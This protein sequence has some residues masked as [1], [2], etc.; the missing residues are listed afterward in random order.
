MERKGIDVSYHQGIIDWKKVKNDG[1]TFAIIRAGYGKKTQDKKF[2]NNIIGAINEGLDI[3]IYWFIYADNVADSVANAEF[4]DI[5]IKLYKSKINLKIWADWEYDSDKRNPQSKASRTDIVEAFC[6][7]LK[8]KGYDVGVYAN[9]DYITSK[10]DMSQ[11]S[12]YPLWLARYSSSKGSYNPFMWQYSSKG[13]VSGIKGN[14][15]MNIM[16][17][18][19]STK[20]VYPTLKVGSKGEYVKIVQKKVGCKVDGDFGILTKN[21]VIVFQEQNGLVKDGI[22]GPKTWDKILNY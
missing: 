19:E 9:P 17:G 12:K 22:V 5:V 3:G 21:H 11:L 2:S 13:K 10:F 8:A 7:T 16:Y 15:D 1:V 20:A 14:V 6:K 18:V 4:C